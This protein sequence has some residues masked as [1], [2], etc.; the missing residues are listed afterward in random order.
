MSQITDNYIT[1]LAKYLTDLSDIERTNNLN[2]Y[3]EF[4][5]DGDFQTKE[6]IE[7][8]LGTPA[9]LAKLIKQD[10]ERIKAKTAVS[11]NEASA[12]DNYVRGFHVE[13][14]PLRKRTILPTKFG[15]IKLS[16]INA[17]VFIHQGERLAIFIAD[18]NS[19]PVNAVVANQ[20]L[21][22]DELPSKEENHHLLLNWQTGGSRIEVIIPKQNSITKISGTNIDGDIILQNLQL[23]EISLTQRNGN[24]LI[25]NVNVNRNF[26]LSSKNGDLTLVQTKIVKGIFDIHNGDTNIK[27]SILKRFTLESTNGD[28]SFSQCN[29]TLKFQAKNGDIKIK[30]SQFINKTTII[31]A[32][33]DLYLNQLAHDISYQ[34]ATE[35]GNIIY[36]RSSIGT[37]FDSKT[38][39]NDWL[40]VTANTGDIIIY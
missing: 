25:N 15:K 33:G 31:L 8:E 5:L 35:H 11:K 16:L 6:E 1:N 18:Y 22:I 10:Y 9:E 4:L 24:T 29:L 13:K 36:H 12:S 21:L 3:R 28:A 37:K 19:R 38:S 30:Q 23:S 26:Q 32:A 7:K 40:K 34:L 17:D 39:L 14:N 27:R 2:F 20:T